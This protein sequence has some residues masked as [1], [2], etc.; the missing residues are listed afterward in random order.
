MVHFSIHLTDIYEWLLHARHCLERGKLEKYDPKSGE[1][2]EKELYLVIQ[3]S[4]TGKF[5]LV[6][7]I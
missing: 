4:T 3:E 7:T 2:W 6:N 5:C 1:M